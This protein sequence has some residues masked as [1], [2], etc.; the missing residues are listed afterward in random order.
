LHQVAKQCTAKQ[1]SPMA[2]LATHVE[3]NKDWY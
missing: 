1:K 3:P 2:C